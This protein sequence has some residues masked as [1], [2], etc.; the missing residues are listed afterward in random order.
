MTGRG[1]LAGGVASEVVHQV[2]AAL[3]R[4][5]WRIPGSEAT[6]L[7]GLGPPYPLPA[8]GN[9]DNAQRIYRGRFAFAGRTVDCQ[10]CH[11][12]SIAPPSPAWSEVLHGFAWLADLEAA[13]LALYRAFARTLLETWWS[14]PRRSTHAATCRRL[15]SLARHGRFLLA[16]ASAE[17]EARFFRAATAE[18]RRLADLRPSRPADRLQQWVAVLHAALAFRGAAV[19]RDRALSSLARLAPSLILPDGGSFDRSPRSLLEFLSA[20]L[21]LRAVLGVHGLAVPRPLDQAIERALPM[22]RMLC[23]GDGG[24]AVFHGV[25]QVDAGTVR[26]VLEADTSRST[27]T[28]FAPHAGYCRM[29]RGTAVAIVDCGPSAVCDSGLALEFS[30]GAQRIVVSCGMPANASP[31]WREAAA[32]PAA[33]S[34]LQIDGGGI[35]GPPS[36]LARRARGA[37]ANPIAVECIA[38]PHGTLVK[39]QSA[40]HAPAWGIEYRRELFLADGGGD[41]R[42]E[43][44]FAPADRR[45]RDRPLAPFAIRFHLHPAI[46]ASVDRKGEAVLLLLPGKEAWQFSARGGAL[47]VEDSIYL[48]DPAGPRRCRQIVIRGLAG[49][50]ERVNW[51]F[52]KLSRPGRNTEARETPPRLPF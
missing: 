20:V 21:P 15:Q 25:E 7:A 44:R 42:G 39:A 10:P 14:Q 11:I 2:A 51:A 9:A 6:A 30:D 26:S 49:R 4:L 19:L 52:R 17:F 23:H 29:N 13:D 31:A 12:F 5:R 38:S 35:R 50:P 40:A 36:F 41:L 3:D 37:P 32:S 46:K 18:T 24:L 34:M 8:A 22:L 1:R 47:S 43:D 28:P 45:E 48:S 16:G 33:H 27:A